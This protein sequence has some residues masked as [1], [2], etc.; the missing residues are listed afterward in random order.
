MKVRIISGFLGAGKTTFL[1]KLLPK[2]GEQ[3]VVIENEFGEASIDS[4][5]VKDGIPVREIYAGCICCSLAADFQQALKDIAVEQKEQQVL[6]EPSGVGRLSDVAKACKDA[7]NQAGIEIE[8]EPLITIVDVTAFEDDRKQFGQFYLDQI[9]N[10][11][12]IFLSY[13]EELSEADLSVRMEEIHMLNPKAAIYKENWIEKDGRELLAFLKSVKLESREL[14]FS[15]AELPDEH[16]FSS[17]FLESN[18]HASEK[19]IR[20][21]I[22]KWDSGCYGTILR[23]KGIILTEKTAEAVDYT[24]YHYTLSAAEA[25]EENGLVLIGY[26]LDKK[27]LAADMER[28][29]S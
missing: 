9:K 6:I 4:G 18:G 19:E 7:G 24:P 8:I 13:I 1:N 15:H 22:A 21:W 12:V 11:D 25:L 29:T 26:H 16:S 28:R 10:A 14:F 23:A 17:V 2:M 5:R 20:Q 3:T 27:A